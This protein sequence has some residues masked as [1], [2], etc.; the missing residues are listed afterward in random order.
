MPLLKIMKNT[1]KQKREIRKKRVFE[2]VMGNKDKPRISVFRS[3]KHIYTQLVDDVSGLT[4]VSVNDMDIKKIKNKKPT[5]E[6]SKDEK[7]KKINI[8]FQVGE[9]L[10]KKALKKK[11]KKAVFDKSGYKYHGR[12]KSLAEGARKGGLKF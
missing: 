6:N 1:K 9:E 12:V 5:N 3:N 10:A 8:S 11:I 7:F 4:L 2:K